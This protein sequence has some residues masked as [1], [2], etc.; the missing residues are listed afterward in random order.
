MDHR[1]SAAD[2]YRRADT[3]PLATQASHPE[4]V[5]GLSA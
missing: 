5:D 2:S 4:I 3:A 1:K